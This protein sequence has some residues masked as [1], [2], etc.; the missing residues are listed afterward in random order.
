MSEGKNVIGGRKLTKY[1]DILKHFAFEVIE[2]GQMRLVKFLTTA[3]MAD[4]LTKGLHL[5]PVF[6]CVD[7][8]LYQQ[9]AQR[10][11]MT[12]VLQMGW[13]AKATKS[14]HVGTYGG[15]V[16]RSNW[17][18]RPKL[19]IGLDPDYPRACNLE[20]GGRSVG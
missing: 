4:I 8:L 14:S 18:P 7:G 20:S 16:S 9:S 5:P 19:D 13:F 2:N 10:T 1:I 11:L 12:F 3:Q 17:K 6:A 15:G